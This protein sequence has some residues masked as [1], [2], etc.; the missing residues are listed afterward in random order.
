M[1]Q[2]ALIFALMASAFLPAP[3]VYGQS[4]QWPIEAVTVYERGAKIERAE[5]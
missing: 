4:V 2:N 1:K 3:R 5:P